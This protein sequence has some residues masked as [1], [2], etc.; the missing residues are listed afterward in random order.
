MG[1]VYKARQISLQRTVAL[2]MILAGQLA[3]PA[4]VQRFHSEAEAAANLDHAHIVPIHEVGEWN[5]QHYFS[6][7]LVEGGS[8]TEYLD[9]YS[10]DP[11][12][13]VQMLI[14]V[15][16][17][18]HHAHQRGILHRDLKPS[19][20]LLDGGP[21]TPLG[22]RQPHVTDFGLAKRVAGGSAMTQSGAILG[23][24]SYM[25]PEQA[26]G[27]KGLTTT[28]SDVYSL[29][30]ILYE[31]L[32][33]RPPFRADSPFDTL[34]QVLEHEPE[35][36][37]SLN[38][39][40]DRDLETICLKCLEKEPRK[41]YG[42]AEAL[43]DD[44]QRWLEGE[45]IKARRT[46]RWERA[47]KWV[48]RRPAAAALLVVSVVASVLLVAALVAL[49]VRTEESLRALQSEQQ[50]TRDQQQQTQE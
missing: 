42:S 24:P 23:T 41:R 38:P 45:P 25:P 40:T 32:T 16:R 7:K 48:K 15:A 2:K 21:D 29:G 9:R 22:Q 5:G 19:N 14:T 47:L 34:L 36:P 46:S 13:A 30:A 18:V 11:R 12:A 44:L 50:K 39:K 26:L 37:R 17:A 35:R 6:M 3:S 1:V 49:N 20:I 43:A 28:A 33:K 27:K 10:H 8:L 4:D 31:L